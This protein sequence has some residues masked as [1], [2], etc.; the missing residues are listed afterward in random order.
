MHAETASRNHLEYDD[1]ADAYWRLTVYDSVHEGWW[2]ASIGGRTVLDFIGRRAALSERSRALEFC[3]GI[4]DTCRYLASHFG[5]T[6]QGIEINQHQIARARARVRDADRHIA[7][8][9]DFV[10]GDVLEWRASSGYDVVYAIDALML[11]EQRR[12]A[13]ET[14]RAALRTTGSLIF[15]EVLAGPRMTTTVR[16]FVREE[17]GIINLP[18][19]EEQKQMLAS[20]GFTRIE[21]VDRTGLA[22]RCFD[23]VELATRKH[24][25]TLIQ[26]KGRARYARWLRNAR[27][28]QRRFKERSLVYVVIAAVPDHRL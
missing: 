12:R 14:A 28:Y 24:A 22:E 9:I 2:F 7:E 26:A 8:R 6:V 13:L 20:A 4:G 16:D 25:P 11:L 27:L 10:Q 18:T 21:S 23:R 17:D 1:A 3:S 15:A 5:C 19:V